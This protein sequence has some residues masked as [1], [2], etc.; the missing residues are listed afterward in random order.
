[1]AEPNGF[2]MEYNVIEKGSVTKCCKIS[3][4]ASDGINITNDFWLSSE[5]VTQ[6]A[7][8]CSLTFSKSFT[9]SKSY[10]A[11]CDLYAWTLSINVGR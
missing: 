8:I 4:T 7:R 6:G 9:K 2:I 10:V 5:T 1:M 11:H 3:V